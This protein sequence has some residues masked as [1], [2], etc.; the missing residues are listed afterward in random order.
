MPS[1]SKAV[2]DCQLVCYE[3]DV[4]DDGLDVE[5]DEHAGARSD[6]LPGSADGDDVLTTAT[7]HGGES[8]DVEARPLTPSPATSSESDSDPE[9]GVQQ[10][11]VA[12]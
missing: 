4:E 3:L 1:R 5:D 6:R 7:S 12:T 2:R 8:L 9:T 10:V 11:G